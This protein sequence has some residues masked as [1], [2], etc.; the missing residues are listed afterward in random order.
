MEVHKLN[1]YGEIA[2]GMKDMLVHVGWKKDFIVKGTP[3]MPFSG[4][5]GGNLQS[6]S[7]H[8]G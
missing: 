6:K 8:M 3:V 4:W 5:M 2:D 1:R 7:T